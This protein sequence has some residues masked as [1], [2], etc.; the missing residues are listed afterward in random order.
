MV[1]S[2]QA[3]NVQ[4]RPAGPVAYLDNVVIWT[5]SSFKV[6][7]DQIGHLRTLGPEYVVETFDMAVG[8]CWHEIL[9]LF[10]L[11]SSVNFHVYST[12]EQ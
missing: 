11:A 10:L 1:H 7:L 12:T 9:A 4:S 5:L 8:E 3:N 2:G 6:L